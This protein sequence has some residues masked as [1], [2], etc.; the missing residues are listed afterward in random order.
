[1]EDGPSVTRRRKG[2]THCRKKGQKVQ[3]AMYLL[4]HYTGCVGVWVRA[5]GCAG[6]R[7]CAD[8]GY[9]PLRPRYQIPIKYLCTSYRLQNAKCTCCSGTSSSL[10]K[11]P[12]HTNSRL[13]PWY[14]CI[15]FFRS[16]WRYIDQS[17][18][19]TITSRSITPLNTHGRY[20][21]TY[22]ISLPQSQS[23]ST[24]KLP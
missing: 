16:T 22:Q 3:A 23:L 13:L 8:N 19:L 6:V 15:I 18:I 12:V 20:L 10:E 14:C 5:C 11:N 9:C 1:M 4:L 17:V 2:Q 7:V 24:G 21:P